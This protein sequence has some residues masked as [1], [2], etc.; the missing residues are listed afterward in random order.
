MRTTYTARMPGGMFPEFEPTTAPA[1]PQSVPLFDLPAGVGSAAKTVDYGT[2]TAPAR[3]AVT[4]GLFDT[5]LTVGNGSFGFGITDTQDTFHYLGV[6]T[7]CTRPIRTDNTTGARRIAASCPEC[8]NGITCERLVAVTTV[9]VCDARCMNATGPSCSCAC[10]GANHGGTWGVRTR[11]DLQFVS[12]LENYRAQVTRTQAKKA[13]KAQREADRRKAAFAEWAT[14]NE[15]QTVLS[16]LRSTD[17]NNSFL[18]DMSA[19]I[20]QG[21]MLTDRQVAGVAKF[22]ENARKADARRAEAQKRQAEGKPAPVGKAVAVEGVIVNVKT[23]DGYTYGSVTTRMLVDCVDGYRVYV[24]VP[25]S[26]TPVITVDTLP[27]LRGRK[28][29]FVADLEPARNSDDSSFTYGK[30]P[31]KAQ[32]VD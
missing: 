29:R 5:T 10:G 27:A 25:R 18:D 6:C 1:A 28:V 24:T 32:F 13:A 31:R 11:T 15:V 22:A 20:E 23:T 14:D 19:L 26:L 7:P 2:P 21:R 17:I 3:S 9:D 4:S 8:G 16:F 12:A 30:R